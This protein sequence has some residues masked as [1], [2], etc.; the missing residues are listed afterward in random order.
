MR[1]TLPG[2]IVLLLLS[3]KT[4][5]KPITEEEENV[6][7][8]PFAYNVDTLTSLNQYIGLLSHR[9]IR[10]EH[11]CYTI[12][13]N[14]NVVDV[15]NGIILPNRNVVLHDGRIETILQNTKKLPK[16]EIPRTKYK[17][18]HNYLDFHLCI[19]SRNSCFFLL[20][21]SNSPPPETVSTQG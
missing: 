17:A 3:C 21:I 10:Q 16:M 5:E 6:P 19:L 9:K 12:I 14:V 18:S 7:E 2:L 20:D 11:Y 8:V 1:L 4:R 15:A 13:A